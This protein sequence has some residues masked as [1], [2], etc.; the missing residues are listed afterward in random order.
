MHVLLIMRQ[1][2]YKYSDHIRALRNLG[3]YVHI[4]TEE[5]RAQRDGLFTSVQII[6]YGTSQEAILKIAQS[7]KE[8]HTLQAVFTFL[9]REIIL[10][11]EVAESLKIPGLEKNPALIARDKSKQRSLLAAHHIPSPE[12]YEVYNIDEALTQFQ[13]NFPWIVK[14]T[15]A[16]LSIGVYLVRNQKELQK[17]L[18]EIYAFSKENKAHY[19]ESK[20]SCFALIEE[21]L[22]G[23]EVTLDGVVLDGQ[24]ILGGIHN[25]WRNMGPTFEEDLYSLPFKMPDQEGHLTDIA[26]SICKAL[27]LK[28][29]MFNVEMRQNRE[30][31][32]KVL[33]F[34]TRLSGAF[35]YR[36]IK[37]VYALD[38]VSLYAK[39]LL[40][41]PITEREKTRLEPTMTTCTKWIF[42][43]GTVHTN[44]VGAAACSPY[45]QDYYPLAFPGQI[46][47]GLPQDIGCVGRVSLYAPYHSLQDVTALEQFA[48]DFIKTLDIHVYPPLRRGI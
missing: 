38:M 26:V 21:F 12:H 14:P 6:P 29:G 19:Y 34:S 39:K 30:G 48:C 10:A 32:F 41:L 28:N 13:D 44:S 25:K 11:A 2:Y 40:N 45:F 36:H 47:H 46:L 8:K 24:F 23:E 35:C 15:Q 43:V 22:P 18:K 3:L 16:A 9:E 7:I 33:E 37:D 17:R 5:E 27:K 4:I 1:A 31:E 42:G 20:H